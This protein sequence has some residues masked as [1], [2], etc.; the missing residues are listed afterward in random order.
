MIMGLIAIGAGVIILAE[1]GLGILTLAL[2]LSIT[3]LI[4]GISRLAR[5]LS[6]ELFTK[7]HRALDVIA[8][9]ISIILGLVVS[10]D[11]ML[12]AST[13]VLLLAFAAMIY[14]ITTIILG[15]LVNRLPKFAR[16][17]LVLTG[18]LSV[19]FSVAVLDLPALGLLT[20]V[21]MLT[22]SFLVN[23]IESIVSAL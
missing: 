22:V 9:V 3:L 18:I 20:L 23:G 12:G 8:G 11:P 15:A 21:V 10:A 1:P 13:I 14:G 6:H 16:G 19:I 17:F 7:K 4:L 5:G 2:I